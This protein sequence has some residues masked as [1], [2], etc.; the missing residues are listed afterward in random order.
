MLIFSCS[1]VIDVVIDVVQANSFISKGRSFTEVLNWPVAEVCRDTF[2][3]GGAVPFDQL[4]LLKNKVAQ[5]TVNS[6][7]AA[8]LTF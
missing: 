2:H 5:D 4:L 8:W 3:G 1:L 6:S 7:L